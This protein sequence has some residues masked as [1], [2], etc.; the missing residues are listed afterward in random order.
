MSNNNNNKDKDSLDLAGVSI[1]L[2]EVLK[3]ALKYLVEGSAVA[4]AA[5][6]IPN[7]KMSLEEAALIGLTA[8]AILAVLDLL[9]PN[10]AGGARRGIGFGIG[11]KQVGF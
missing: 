2:E 9:S 4:A 11:L 7:K 1:D 10:L 5:F 8:A 3:R 6:L